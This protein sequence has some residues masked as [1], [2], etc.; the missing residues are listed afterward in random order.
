M[1]AAPTSGFSAFALEPFP[2]LKM[3]DD[4]A[5]T[6]ASVLT[7][8]GLELKD[9]DVVVAASMWFPMRRSGTSI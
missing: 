2:E 6:I 7:R 4:L 5:G 8:T 1:T 9:G 3:G